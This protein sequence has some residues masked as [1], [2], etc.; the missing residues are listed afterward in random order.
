MNAESQILYDRDPRERVQKVAPFL[1][2]DGD[3]YPAVVDGRIPGSSTATRRPTH[4]PYSHAPS[5]GRRDDRL[6]DRDAEQRSM[7]LPG[8]NVNYIR[9]SV[10]AT[11]DAYDGR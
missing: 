1:T 6:A 7:A 9:N 10:K 2:L 11:V 4:Y 5:A 8:Q 3:P